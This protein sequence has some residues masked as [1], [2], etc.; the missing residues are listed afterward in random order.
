[1][2]SKQQNNIS[3]QLL[4]DLGFKKDAN[5]SAFFLTKKPNVTVV[6]CRSTSSEDYGLIYTIIGIGKYPE[7][8][9]MSAKD[10]LKNII[11]Y[12]YAD[13]TVENLTETLK[14]IDQT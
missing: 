10:Y 14:V 4:K 3:T 7:L 2:I 12:P 8:K 13:L 11:Q 9:K 1:M 5:H 6:V